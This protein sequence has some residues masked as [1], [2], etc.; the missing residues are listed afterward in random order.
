M[1][2]TDKIEGTCS[3]CLRM[4]Q[5]R[6]D[7]PIRHGFT[8]IGVKHG[9]QQGGYHTGPCEGV[10]YPHLGISCAGT[11]Y[12]L[13]ISTKRLEHVVEWLERLAK[14]PPLTWRGY[15]KNAVP[16][17]INYGDTS[18]TLT[19]S[20]GRP[21]Y[22]YL[23]KQHVDEATNHARQ[24]GEQIKA[25]HNVIDTYSPSKYPT[26]GAVKKEKT[27]H[28]A[29]E[30]SNSRFGKWTGPACTLTR[31]KD[32][33]AKYSITTKPAEVTCTKCQRELMKAAGVK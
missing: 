16:V 31:G 10:D 5:L 2:D 33:A 28:L 3:V 30:F 23:H 9:V 27:V 29:R 13:C 32:A 7:K 8:A 6:G 11:K 25:Y 4:M 21:G 19:H 24:I 18:S 26:K 17:T 22:T 1:A 20:D 12:A 15:G 14:N